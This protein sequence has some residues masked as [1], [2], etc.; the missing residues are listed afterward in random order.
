MTKPTMSATENEGFLTELPVIP[1]GE[2]C[3]YGTVTLPASDPLDMC[4][5]G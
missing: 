1:E 2:F 5:A 4:I 3:V